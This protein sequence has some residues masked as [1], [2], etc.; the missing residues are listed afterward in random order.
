[1]YD[2]LLMSRT[3]FRSMIAMAP[4]ASDGTTLKR[5]ELSDSY[6][7]I[8]RVVQMFLDFIY[9]S[10]ITTL[11]YNVVTR[12]I[13]LATKF[14]CAA[15]ARDTRLWIWTTLARQPD[16]HLRDYL[17][18]AVRLKDVHLAGM[19]VKRMH[20][21]SNAALAKRLER[22]KEYDDI[23]DTD[24]EFRKKDSR[25][26]GY[27]AGEPILNIATWGVRD[28]CRL[29]PHVA[30]AMAQAWRDVY[31]NESW[32]SDDG[33]GPHFAQ[34]FLKHMQ[35]LGEFRNQDPADAEE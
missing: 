19:I 30:W 28:F 34:R 26:A 29:P 16:G 5:I 22:E 11:P 13:D 20:T 9:G 7:E 8:S 33:E 14:D 1:M 31:G 24:Q 18:H 25:F 10:P 17:V 35:S 12:L 21:R 15:V 32:A 6:L 2:S 23:E 3:I 4:A 27:Q